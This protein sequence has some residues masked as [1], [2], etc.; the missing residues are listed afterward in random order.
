[1]VVRANTF[2]VNVMYI[3]IPVC[4]TEREISMQYYK[5]AEMYAA[6]AQRVKSAM[7][8][9]TGGTAFLRFYQK[10]SD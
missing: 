2:R 1:M 5:S 10:M 9:P 7:T 6:N 3:L 8:A 4:L